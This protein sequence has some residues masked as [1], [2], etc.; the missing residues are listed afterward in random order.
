MFKGSSAHNQAVS[1]AAFTKKSAL[2]KHTPSHETEEVQTNVPTVTAS[3]KNTVRGLDGFQTKEDKTTE[4]YK[5]RASFNSEREGDVNASGNTLSNF[6]KYYRGKGEPRQFSDRE[7][8]A[9][10]L[11]M[12]NKNLSKAEKTV[13]AQI[14]NMGTSG[15]W[16]FSDSGVSMLGNGSW[17]TIPQ[18]RNITIM[19]DGTQQNKF[20]V[21]DLS[22]YVDNAVNNV[23]SNPQQKMVWNE[24][25]MRNLQAAA[26]SGQ[27]DDVPGALEFIKYH[28]NNTPT[29]QNIEITYDNTHYADMYGGRGHEGDGGNQ[30][31]GNYSQNMWQINDGDGRGVYTDKRGNL[32]STGQFNP[33]YS[34]RGEFGGY[35]DRMFDAANSQVGRA[36][37]DL[38]EMQDLNKGGGPT[39]RF[40]ENNLTKGQEYF[41]NR[42]PGFDELDDNEKKQVIEQYFPE[43]GEGPT[44]A[45]GSGVLGQSAGGTGTDRG[46]S[47]SRGK[48]EPI[49]IDPIKPSEFNQSYGK[50]TK[51][52]ADDMKG[53]GEGPVDE[54]PGPSGKTRKEKDN[55]IKI[56]TIKPSKI[57]TKSKVDLEMGKNKENFLNQSTDKL[58]TKRKENKKQRE[59][60]QRQAKLD[61]KR[62][63]NYKPQTTVRNNTNNRKRRGNAKGGGGGDF[64]SRTKEFL[65]NTIGSLFKGGGG[66]G[67]KLLPSTMAKKGKY[68]KG[69][70][71]K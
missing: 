39:S 47:D 56:D 65:D 63:L 40:D 36:N 54:R 28:A 27:F 18:S 23:Y 66:G 26:K 33:Q 22:S 24:D 68:N 67:G 31:K 34:N 11:S 21:S 70:K 32:V 46:T 8:A 44:G 58:K 55:I 35:A 48:D 51:G 14:V 10:R 16:E 19:K 49:T 2:K 42:Y 60:E 59:Q 4:K 7:I 1:K 6:E 62:E 12:R 29:D 52:G 15:Q 38:Q 71:K 30:V 20:N 53:M 17:R 3:A 5:N 43:S 45:P 9:I 61:K 64:G 25:T 37:V 50:P 13:L 57:K 69:K 41:K